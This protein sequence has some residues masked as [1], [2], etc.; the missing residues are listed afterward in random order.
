MSFW[1][2]FSG[3]KNPADAGMDY[4]KQIPGSTQPYYQPY[5]D[6]GQ[7]AGKQLGEQYGQMTG[8]PGAFLSKIGAGYKESPGY[9]FKL[10][11]GLGAAQN[12]SAAGGMLGTPQDQQQAQQIGNNIAS[13]DYDDYIKKVLGIFGQGQAGQEKFQ[14]QGFGASTGYGDLLGSNLAQQAGL[15][16][17]G[18]AG[19]NQ[20][21]GQNWS[22]LFN[23][24]ASG[25]GLLAGGPLGGLL[26][27][28]L[29]SS[30]FG[31]GR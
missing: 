23:L 25:L 20:Q 3:G 10:K 8:D 12:A 14:Q 13:Q 16:Y 26:G 30:M 11:Q 22:N 4:L 29:G 1:D 18:Q 31:G 27:G 6:Q 5:I 15:A 28:G 19:Q 17:Q 24:G 21:Q 7:A 9:Q 2:F